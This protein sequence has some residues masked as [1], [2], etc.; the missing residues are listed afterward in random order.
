MRAGLIIGGLFLMFVGIFLFFTLIFTLFGILCGFVGF[1]MLIAG[2][3]TSSPER[4]QYVYQQQPPTVVYPPPQPQQQ[5]YS[6]QAGVKYCVACGAPNSM[7]NQ[8][9]GKCGKKFLE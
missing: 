1:V 4:V 3:A 9:C 5:P 6:N 8:F 7:S 2:L